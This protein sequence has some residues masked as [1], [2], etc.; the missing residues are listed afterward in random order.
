M[1]R[2][3]ACRRARLAICDQCGASFCAAHGL[4][5]ED[6]AGRAWCLA[7]QDEH[8]PVPALVGQIV[9]RCHVG[10]SHRQAIRYFVSRLKRGAWRSLPRAERRQWMRWV[11]RAH[12]ADRRLYSAVMAGITATPAAR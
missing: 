5:D 6:H 3:Y 4:V 12:Q 9:G 1:N 7:C 10:I 11:V 8:D 2:C